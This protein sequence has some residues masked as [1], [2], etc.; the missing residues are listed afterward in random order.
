MVTHDRAKQVKLSP[1]R[2]KIVNG[3]WVFFGVLNKSFCKSKG[4]LHFLF[5]PWNKILF[6]KRRG[7]WQPLVRSK[8]KNDSISCRCE[9]VNTHDVSVF[10]PKPYC[11]AE[12]SLCGLFFGKRKFWRGFVQLSVSRVSFLT[13]D[14]FGI[15][16]PVFRV[17]SLGRKGFA[18][19]LFGIP[20]TAVALAQA[21]SCA[22]RNSD[23]LLRQVPIS[24][25]CFV[26]YRVNRLKFGRVP[27]Q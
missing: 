10:K 9:Q 4:L 22:Q 19:S 2:L 14:P 5:K 26:Q 23:I 13:R 27:R 16:L 17:P 25:E 8:V 20:G 1:E 12:L 3:V 11:H 21:C 7:S 24:P 6:I 18:A 15:R